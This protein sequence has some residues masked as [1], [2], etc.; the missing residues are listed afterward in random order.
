[1]RCDRIQ[2]CNNGFFSFYCVRRS[3]VQSLYNYV[4]D[5]LFFTRLF[6]DK[7]LL[8]KARTDLCEPRVI[9]ISIASDRFY[10]HVLIRNN[11]SHSLART[12]RYTQAVVTILS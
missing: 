12:P 9:V 8:F 10:R 4:Y 1:M 5:R 2:L 11:M 6:G 3:G 7:S